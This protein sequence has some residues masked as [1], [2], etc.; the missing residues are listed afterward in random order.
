MTRKPAFGAKLKQGS[1]CSG[2]MSDRSH[3]C[4]TDHSRVLRSFPI[5]WRVDTAEFSNCP[6]PSALRDGP[7][8]ALWISLVVAVASIGLAFEPAFFS[9]SGKLA[10]SFF[11]AIMTVVLIIY[12]LHLDE[13]SRHVAR[14]AHAVLLLDRAG[15][16]TTDKLAVPRNITLIFLPPDHLS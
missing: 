16:H 1:P 9:R 15:W 10:A 13:I 8:D 5:E 11:V 6:H 3:S 2:H 12:L 4:F 14:G 7:A